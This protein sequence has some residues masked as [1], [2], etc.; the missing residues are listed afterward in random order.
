MGKNKKSFLSTII[1]AGAM[2]GSTCVSAECQYLPLANNL[3]A[4]W[5]KI[6][7]GTETTFKP[8]PSNTVCVDIANGLTKNFFVFNIDTPVTK[9]GTVNGTPAA[10][11]HMWLMGSANLAYIKNVFKNTGNDVS[12][13]FSI[14]GI[15]HSHALE[16]A[17]NDDWWMA[18]VDEDGNQ[19]YPDGNP[20]NAWFDKINWLRAHGMDIQ[21]EVCSVSLSSAGYTHNDV[22]PGILTNQGALGRISV[23][24]QNGYA[25][26]AEGWVDNDSMYKSKDKE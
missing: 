25:V 9:D 8:N 12:G 16:W 2:L 26:V 19:L 20:N 21:L 15:I 24:H 5:D 3:A 13:S 1:F 4:G 11:S 17:L 10:L 18:Q 22:H 23:L 6:I 7:A 14:K